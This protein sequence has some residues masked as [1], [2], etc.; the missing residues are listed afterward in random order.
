MGIVS[1]RNR[2]PNWHPANSGVAPLPAATVTVPAGAV[3]GLV[4]VQEE[5]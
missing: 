5:V 4:T 3:S 1:W 2:S